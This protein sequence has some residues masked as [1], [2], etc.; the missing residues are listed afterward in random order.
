MNQENE[1]LHGTAG[2]EALNDL[3]HEEPREEV[4]T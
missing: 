4:E 2:L 3:C 1:M